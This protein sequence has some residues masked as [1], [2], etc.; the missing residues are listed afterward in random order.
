[1]L[2]ALAR[3]LKPVK[4]FGKAKRGAAALEFAI[5]AM[6]F[7]LLIFGLAEV[8]MIGFVQTSLDFAVSE[9]ARRIRLGEVQMQGQSY[10]QVQTDLCSQLNR[11]LAVT[12]GGNLFLDVDRFNSF[13]DANNA[14]PNP[15][16]NN[17]FQPVGFGYTPGAP[18][19]IVVVR[20]YYRWKIMTP[21]FEDVFANVQGG[22]RILV[23]TMMFRNEPYCSGA[24][25]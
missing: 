4:R 10:A 9:S 1:M 8:A 14:A 16:Q 2:R 15:I 5:V 18:S 21:L 7:F 17:Q 23:S 6:P 24:S 12:C 13:T 20:A 22:E 25:C 11:F 19:D 3:Y